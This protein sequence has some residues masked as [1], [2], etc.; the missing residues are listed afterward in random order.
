MRITQLAETAPVEAAYLWRALFAE[1]YT[2]ANA[3]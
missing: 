1:H 2:E 3:M